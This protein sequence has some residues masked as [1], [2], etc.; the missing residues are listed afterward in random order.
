MLRPYQ[1]AAFEAAQDWMKK[2]TAPA[3]I[4]AATGAGKSHIIAA[5]ADWV[6][7]QSGKKV[8]CLAPSKELTEQN[9][10]KFLATGEP[11]S[12]YSASIGKSLR[13]DVVFG[14]PRTVLNSISNFKNF[15]AIIID[16]C[17]GITPTIQAIIA[18]IQKD[19]KAVRVVGL[20]ATPYRLGSG[21]IYAHDE[22]GRPVDT[23]REPYFDSLI[24]RI[25]A[26]EL[27][28][29]G[30][31]TRP[32]TDCEH[33]AA[34]DTSQMVPN[35]LGKFDDKAFI[36]K[37][38]KTEKIIAEIVAKS[39]SRKGVIIFAASVRH[40]KEVLES[41]PAGSRMITGE[42]KKAEREQIIKSF[43][44]MQI[45]FLVNVSVLTTGFDAPHV[46]VVAI[47]RATESAA[48]LQQI[49][50]RGLR[51]FDLKDNCLILDYAENI[52]RH[53]PDGDIFNPDIS[54]Y[55]KAEGGD[56]IQS[57]C[58]SCQ[59]VN[60]FTGRP[61]PDMFPISKHG[62]FMDLMGVETEMPAHFGRR[63]TG[64]DLIGGEF[65]QCAYR[66]TSKECPD[67]GHHNDITARECEECKFELVDPNEKLQL[68]HA[69]IKANPYEVS[70][71]VVLSWRCTKH[72]SKAGNDTLRIAYTT[73]C[74][75]FDVWYLPQRKRL[76]NDL[77]MAVFGKPAPDVD[78]FL[79]YVNRGEMPTTVTVSKD[80]HSK[81]FTIYGHNR[82][83]T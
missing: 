16:E 48:L 74:R 21:Y 12:I 2:T 82:E 59:T 35:K 73:D 58:P 80:D 10:A 49:I 53:F 39:E 65:F 71:D 14:T 67:C 37:G 30:F 7:S 22:D 63:C 61:N 23:T 78:S 54:V 41:L 40:A 81:F 34:Y 8:L 60:D 66:W 25:T 24:Y 15:A 36:G 62:Y 18:E 13:H 72:V 6:T 47:L 69:R 9:H 68:E 57:T 3:V 45:K 5:I 83:A 52:E 32:I 38:R 11:A 64:R 76:W 26:R 70:S 1:Q 55:Q 56:G 31:L 28:E 46:D 4:E 33:L 77:C 43:K 27:I 79:R 42:T 29:L 50:G 19:N 75:S 44:A 51:L 17:H 20:S